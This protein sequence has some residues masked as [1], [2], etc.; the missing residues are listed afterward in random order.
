MNR[1]LRDKDYLRQIQE[2]NL[3]QIIENDPTLLPDVE[4]SAQLEMRSYLDI[5]YDCDKVFTNTGTFSITNTYYANNLVEYTEPIWDQTITYPVDSR[6]SWNGIIYVG[7]ASTGVEPGTTSD[8]IYLTED[9]SLYYATTP[10]PNWDYYTQYNVGDIVI[11]NNIT[12]TCIVPV[13]NILPTD[14]NFWTGSTTYSFTGIYPEYT[15]YWTKGDNRNSQ[16]VMYLIDM[17]LYHL[18]SRINPRNIPELRLIRYDGNGPHQGGGSIGFLKRA[19]SG[20]VRLNI[21]ERMPDTGISI[22]WGNNENRN[23]Y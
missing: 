16:V 4:A 5:R 18:H 11:Y 20:D 6:V 15:T 2:E 22:T 3:N 23:I 9:L 7:T 13:I 12:Y 19:S 21:A 17:T 10:Y 8:W 14:S 1:L